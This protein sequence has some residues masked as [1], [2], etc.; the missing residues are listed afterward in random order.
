MNEVIAMNREFF[1]WIVD[2]YKNGS[3]IA[4][5]CV[6]A[7]LLAATGLSRW[8]KVCDALDVPERI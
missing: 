6:G 8:K 5:L 4:S 1:P 7:F 2:H 3:E